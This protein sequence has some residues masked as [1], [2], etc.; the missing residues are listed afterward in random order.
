MED[1]SSELEQFRQQWRAEVSARSQTDGRR[2][3]KAAARSRRPPPVASQSS[4]RVPKP[5]RDAD[6]EE[7][8]EPRHFDAVHGVRENPGHGDSSKTVAEE[9]QSALE[10]YEKAVEREAAGNLGDSL[11]LYRK[12]FHVRA[13]TPVAMD[14]F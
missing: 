3:I 10:H 12:A 5:P 14:H 11:T 8:L 9:P 13:T 6:A 7:D 1:S 2:E 4:S